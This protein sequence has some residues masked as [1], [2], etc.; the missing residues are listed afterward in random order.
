M[1]TLIS[2]VALLAVGCGDESGIDEIYPVHG[3]ISFDGQPLVE[4][5]TTVLFQPDTARGNEGSLV[6]VGTVDGDG[7]YT[8]STKGRNGACPGWYKVV[9]TALAD[10]PQHPT[11][12]IDTK[13]KHP[14]AKS[15]LP[16]KYGLAA[17][18]TLA[19][20]VVAEPD[21]DAYDLNLSSD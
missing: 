5:S 10:T 12:P 4:E 6:A 11:G 19:V 17:T 3:K 8:V 2:L 14:V 16:A 15:L 7:N 1:R 21:E 20:E 18:T 9:V 13:R